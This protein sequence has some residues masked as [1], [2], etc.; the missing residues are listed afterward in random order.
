MRQSSERLDV[1]YQKLV[2]RRKLSFCNAPNCCNASW[3][4][5]LSELPINESIFGHC[6]LLICSVPLYNSKIFIFYFYAPL[7]LPK[8][9]AAEAQIYA[10]VQLSKNEKHWARA[11]DWSAHVSIAW[12]TEPKSGTFAICCQWLMFKVNTNHLRH[13]HLNTLTGNVLPLFCWSCSSA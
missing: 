5:F 3:H 4:Q 8:E 7:V 13:A 12:W 10:V 11:L 1:G 9:F 2:P 6:K